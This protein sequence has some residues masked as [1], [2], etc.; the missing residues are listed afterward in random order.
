M[1]SLSQV[2]KINPRVSWTAVWL[3]WR[4]GLLAWLP[5]GVRRW[6]AGTS[7]RLVIAVDDGGCALVREEAGQAQELER[8]APFGQGNSRP[9]LCTSGATLDG[10]NGLYEVH[11]H[12]GNVL[13]T[14]LLL[15]LVLASLAGIQWRRATQQTEVAQEEK[16]RAE[17]EKERAYRLAVRTGRRN[18]AGPRTRIPE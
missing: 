18:R 16:S 11:A 17:Q 4:D 8:L 13:T 1:L 7:R 14:G 9:L 6:L 15:A 12:A 10:N 5:A 3:W 2:L